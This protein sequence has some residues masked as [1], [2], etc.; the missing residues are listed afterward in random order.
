MDTLLKFVEEK[1][2]PPLT[3]LASQHHLAATKDGMMVTLPLTII[4]SIFVLIANFPIDAWKTFLEPYSAMLGAMSTIT[5]GIVAIVGAGSVAYYFALGYNNNKLNPVVA[6]FISIA[7]F[8]LATL[9]EE[10]A[11]DTSLFGTR[12]L[13]TAIVIAFL[14]GTIYHF[15]VKRN[16]VIK[17][18]DSVPPLVS[19]SFSSLIPATVSLVFIWFVRVVLGFDINSGLMGL[20]SPFVFALNTLPGFLVFMF[21]RSML[22]SVGIHGGAVLA[23]ADPFFLTM[24]GENLAAF[25]AGTLAPYITASGFTM[26]VF[27]GGGG[28]TLALV[29]MMCFSKEPG[30][31]T[32]GRLSLPASL[33]EINEP[34]VFGVPLVMNPL[35][36]IPY[37]LTTLVL[38]AGTYGLMYF[39]IIGRPVAQIPWTMPPLISHYLVTGGDWRAIIW[40]VISIAISGAIY[41]PFFKAMESNRLKGEIE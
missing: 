17:F 14:T 13:F 6:G 36:I 19:S 22:W 28:T 15:F 11:I 33:F 40:G 8:L 10:Y 39:N 23:V 25:E 29:C 21:I 1:L 16:L 35:M 31:K 27:I 24:F 2:S 41:Y 5:M 34:V 7:G 32:L 20:F 4:G 18:P 37:T 12:G 26:F 9:N 30:F 38:S 3:K